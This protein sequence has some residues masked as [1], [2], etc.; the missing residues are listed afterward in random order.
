VKMKA[1]IG[2]FP[3]YLYIG[4]FPFE[5]NGSS[6]YVFKFGEF[7][8]L[9]MGEKLI[10]QWMSQL[11]AYPIYVCTIFSPHVY[12]LFQEDC[13]KNGIRI[14]FQQNFNDEIE[15]NV[16]ILNIVEIKNAK[17]FK[18]IMIHL[19]DC[20][21]DLVLWSSNK[22]AFTIEK[23]STKYNGKTYMLDRVIVRMSEE[24]SVFWIDTDSISIYTISNNDKFSDFRRICET[25]PSFV[26]PTL[27]TYY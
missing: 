27:T 14:T 5:V 8:L 20:S 7:S 1:Q 21:S 9:E 19:I 11:S 25:L 13:N 22:K 24:S 18:N 26:V 4:Y 15:R 12:K 3:D 10:P 23:R 16:R 2:Y 6:K 17:Q